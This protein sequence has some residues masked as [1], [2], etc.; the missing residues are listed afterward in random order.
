[1]GLLV[2]PD[3]CMGAHDG[4]ALQRGEKIGAMHKEI[5]IGGL[6]VYGGVSFSKRTDGVNSK[7]EDG[8]HFLMWDFDNVD[9]MALLEGLR[10]VQWNNSLPTIYILESTPGSYH[11]Y[12]FKR[13]DWPTTLH[14]LADTYGLDP[15]YF[16][17]GVLRGFFTL[18][19]KDKSGF[20]IRKI[21]ELKSSMPEDVDPF[22]EIKS[23][24][25]YWTK[26]T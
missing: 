9:Y 24:S 6:R 17:I 21:E 8:T 16:K 11:A 12:C 7:L 15:A 4:K 3:C 19:I 14:I 23:F 2:V 13:K 1:M 5:N 25:K 10:W 20:Q 26:R 22:E 18:R